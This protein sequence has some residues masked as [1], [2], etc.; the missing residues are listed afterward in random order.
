MRITDIEI[1]NFRAFRGTYRVELPAAGQNLLVYG[2]N[3][4]GKSS[5]YLALKFFLESGEG[6]HQ[7][8]KYQNVFVEDKGY[9]KLGLQG[10]SQSEQN[11]YEWSEGIKDETTDPVI[12]AA[13]KAKRIP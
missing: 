1:K 9:I 10:N 6:A 2:E 13:S 4:N 11:T 5:L 3:G 12:I 8:E 7:F